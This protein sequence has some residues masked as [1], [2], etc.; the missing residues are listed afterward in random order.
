MKKTI[1][2]LTLATLLLSLFTLF[3][4][5]ASEPMATVYVT[6]ADKDGKLAV[7]E[8]AINLSDTDGDGELTITDALYLA[9]EAKYDGGAEAGYATSTTQYGLGMTKL[10]GE[11]NGG[12]Y[13][14]YLNNASAYNLAEKLKDGDRITAFVYTDL[15]TWSDTFCYF[16]KSSVEGTE[17]D[18]VTLTL[19]SLSWDYATNQ[20]VILPVANA[21]VTVDGEATSVKTDSEGK[22]TLELSAGVHIISATS[23]E[24][25]LVP[26]VCRVEAASLTPEPEAPNMDYTELYVIGIVLGAAIATVV[27]FVVIK[28]KKK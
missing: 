9:H 25:T 4:A 15:S 27:V 2:L 10:W 1:T 19:S 7:A 6:I 20:N 21:T 5:A 14:Y 18:T 26:P 3:T 8:E 22:A 24:Q 16:D 13:G 12:S 11:E 17:G 23:E 28:R